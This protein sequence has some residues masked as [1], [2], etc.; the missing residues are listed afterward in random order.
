LNSISIIAA[1]IFLLFL[2]GLRDR[3]IHQQ[4]AFLVVYL[5]ALTF[6]GEM[7]YLLPI[8]FVVSFLPFTYRIRKISPITLFLLA[9]NLSYILYGVLSQNINGTI[10]TFISKMWQF[11]V[12]FLVF[13]SSVRIQELN[14]KRLIRLLFLCETALGVFLLFTSTHQSTSGLVRLVTNSQPITGNIAIIAL[15]L[16][17]YHYY[18][19]QEEAKECS[20]VIRMS[21][22]FLVWIVLSGTRGYTL[23]FVLTMI[24]VYFDYFTN[25]KRERKNRIN[26]YVVLFFLVLASVILVVLIPHLVE[27]FESI[28]RLNTATGIRQYEN[29]AELEFYWNAP[30]HI[31]LFGIGFGGTAGNFQAMKDA[32][33]K[34]FSLGMWHQDKYWY[35]SGALFHNLFANI[36][37]CEGL[38]G[39]G[40]LFVQNRKMWKYSSLVGEEKSRLRVTL[41]L[42]QI[43][44]LL[45]NYYRWSCTC[46]ISEM[47]L[48]ALILKYI[49]K[50]DEI[51]EDSFAQPKCRDINISYFEN[52]TGQIN[53]K[54]N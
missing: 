30:I 40:I 29:A 18:S 37:L 20:W 42:F 39:I 8:F 17:V 13:D 38:L 47:I 3:P 14:C 21:L 50:K 26:R 51:I 45:M 15:L 52:R 49:L 11:T 7:D 10:V 4:A 41:H 34:Q 46:G 1:A 2:I 19:H 53:E 31:Q 5:V 25:G 32:L 23:V 44:F 16:L 43:G 28:L 22:L 9:F 33:S 54:T 48:F 36:L 6:V 35:G 24:T 12:F 27:R